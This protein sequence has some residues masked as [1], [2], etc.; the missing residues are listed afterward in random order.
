MVNLFNGRGDD[1]NL[2]VP[3]IPNS[4]EV[5]YIKLLS[6]LI[7]FYKKDLGENLLNFLHKS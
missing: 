1:Y 2:K 5:N 4:V 6:I 3:D 7:A